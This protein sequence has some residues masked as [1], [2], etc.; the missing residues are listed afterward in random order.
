MATK[1][2]KNK[3]VVVKTTTTSGKT[4]TVAATSINTYF[5]VGD[6]ATYSYNGLLLPVIV[7]G[8]HASNMIG[9]DGDQVLYTVSGDI[10]GQSY[11][12]GITR[13]PFVDVPASKLSSRT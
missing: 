1:S 11:P 4:S 8:Q 10:G 3:D 5:S 12:A 6:T 7:V 13:G 2:L 9:A